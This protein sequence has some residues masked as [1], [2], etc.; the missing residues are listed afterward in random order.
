MLVALPHARSNHPT[1]RKYFCFWAFME[2]LRDVWRERRRL[3]LLL[4]GHLRRNKGPVRQHLPSDFPESAMNPNAAEATTTRTLLDEHFFAQKAIRSS[5]HY[6]FPSHNEMPNVLETR[7]KFIERQQQQHIQST[8][9]ATGGNRSFWQSLWQVPSR[10][11]A[12]RNQER[13][14]RQS[15]GRGLGKRICIVGLHGWIPTKVLQTVIGVPRGT[16]TRLCQMMEGNVKEFLDRQPL[17]Y[18]ESSPKIQLIPLEGS[19]C[20]EERVA[21]HYAQLFNSSASLTGDQEG[22]ANSN[23][24][25]NNRP[26]DAIRTADSVI[27]IAHSQGAPVASLL[28][29]RLLREG[30]LQPMTGQTVALLTLAAVFHGPFPDLRENLVVR[31]VEADAA[32]ELFD[33]NDPKG[34]LSVK[35][36]QS[37]TTLLHA[38]VLMASV[39]SWMDQVVPLYSATLLGIEHENVWRAIYIDEHNYRPDFLSALVRFALKLTNAQV[40]G[41]RQMLAQLSGHLSGSMYQSNA[42]STLYNDPNVYQVLLHWIYCKE[43]RTGATMN[44]RSATNAAPS[45]AGTASLHE[46]EMT[47]QA[48]PNPYLLPWTMRSILATLQSIELLAT[49]STLATDLVQLRHLHRQWHPDRKSWRD[50]ARQFAPLHAKL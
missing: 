30:Y 8:D 31:Y 17:A 15:V 23:S 10:L 6:L 25:E 32:R 33:L 26:I 13:A 12:P 34:T 36:Q 45:I 5:R 14:N 18:F 20:I 28:A 38:D 3:L 16:S 49:D 48:T 9:Q 11:F 37:L 35:I 40:P 21:N 7:K 2:A 29:A 22:G 27:F 4:A 39:A 44:D 43:R 47:W 50:L 24:S 41:A 42:H 19:G 1:K 46:N